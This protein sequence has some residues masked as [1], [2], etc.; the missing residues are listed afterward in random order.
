[1]HAHETSQHIVD[2]PPDQTYLIACRYMVYIPENAEFI[3]KL[4][5][6][7]P[8]QNLITVGRQ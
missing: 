2:I 5:K 6:E 1:M 3:L 7:F 4:V 8:Y